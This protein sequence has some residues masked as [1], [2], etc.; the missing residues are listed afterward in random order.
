MPQSAA[1]AKPVRAHG[2]RFIINVLWSWTGVAASLFQGLIITPFIIRRLGEEHYGIWLIIFSILEYFWFFDLGLNTAVCVFCARY[3]AVRDHEKINRVI[4]TA[5]FYF[6]LIAL[7]IWAISPVLAANAYRF[8]PVSPAYRGEF[9]TLILITGI[10]W[11]LCVML[12]L[13]LSALDGF[14]RFDLTSRVMVLQVALRSVGYF[15]ALKFGYGLI[16]MAEVFV[17]TQIMGYV[18]NFLNFR[19][20]FPALR[21]TPSYVSMA[22]FREILQYGLKSFVAGL[23][24]LGLNQSGTLMVTHFLGAAAAGFYGLPSRLL[25]QPVDAVS[26]VANVTR[27]KSAELSVTETQHANVTLGIYTNRYSLTLFMVPAV[28]L[29]VYGY[30]LLL[31]WVGPVMAN[32]SGPLLPIFLLAY[33]LVL[34]AQYN[35]S[36]LLYGVGRHGGYARGLV[37][38]AVVYIA[39]LAFVVPRYG[40]LGAAWATAVMMILV[41]GIYTPWLVAQALDYPWLR[42]MAGIYA[43]PLG[44][45]IPA[46]AAAWALRSTVMPGRSIPELI[47]AGCITS[48]I[49]VAVAFFACVEQ[50]HRE[51]ILSRI[52]GLG[53]RLIPRRA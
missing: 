30:P 31:R 22:T 14:Q 48:A 12:H 44:A 34:A 38:E 28:F 37:V 3:I 11:G 53:A 2:E 5:L 25:Q 17:A 35:S 27:S 43:R 47:A 29:L 32:N 15:L 6:S 16:A 23:S 42:Y 52:P 46:V 45:A 40:I 7:V 9:A 26:R 39:A 1:E 8:L 51:M 41:R 20:A 21:V 36:S 18:L 49:Y 10:S 19:R 24:T 4:S 50:H 33:S 13:F